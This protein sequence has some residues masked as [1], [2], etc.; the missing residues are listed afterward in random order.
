MNHASDLDLIILKINPKLSVPL[1]ITPNAGH[2][3]FRGGL[4]K[5]LL[6]F[7]A[8]ALPNYHSFATEIPSHFSST[9]GAVLTCRSQVRLDHL[10]DYMQTY[11]G[12]PIMSDG[13]ANWWKVDAKL[14]SATVTYI[15][16]S[17]TGGKNF[18]GATFNEEANSLVDLLAQTEGIKFTQDGFEKWKSPAFSIILKQNDAVMRS[19]MYCWSIS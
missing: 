3:Y 11:F 7:F 4:A 9:I 17:N 10:N 19:K 1:A 14:F 6:F 5:I 16:V 8:S 18:V 13:G 2:L 15:F 12:E